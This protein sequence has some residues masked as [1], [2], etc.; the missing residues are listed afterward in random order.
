MCLLLSINSYARD[1]YV[2]NTS[3]L[4]NACTNAAP[5]DVIYIAAGTYQGPFVLN[6]KENITLRSYNGPV[7]LEGS[8]TAT[9]NGIIILSIQNSSNITVRDL[10]LRNNWGNFADGIQIRGSGDGVSIANCEFFNIGW[11][12]DKQLLPNAGQNAH[13]IIAVG[14]EATS[15]SNLFI[16]GNRIHDC[17]TGYSES[18]TLAGNVEFFLVEGNRLTNNTNIG[19]D[20]AGHFPWT[21]APA[22]VNFARSGIIRNNVVSDY[23]G[24]AALDAAGGIYVDGGSFVTVEN[25]TVY[26]YKVGYSI[27]CEVPGNRNSGNILR[28]NVAYNCS[29]SGAFIG[30]NTS[31]TVSNTLVQNNTFYKCGF[32]TF[33]NGQLA[34][35][36]NENTRVINNIMYPTGGRTAMVQMGGT[37]SSSLTL[38][39]NLYWRDSG[40]TDNLFFGISGDAAAVLADPLFVGAGAGDFH[41][42]ND[43]PAIDRGSMSI[44][45]TGQVDL[46]ATA[47]VVNGTVDIG[48]DEFAGA[49]PVT[50]AATF[51]Q[52]CSFEGTAVSL[53][54][55]SYTLDE[56]RAR[57]ARND[58]FSSLQV[59][60]GYEVTLY[61]HDGFWGDIRTYSADVDCLVRDEFNDECS[62]LEIRAISRVKQAPSKKLTSPGV[63]QTLVYPNPFDRQLTFG[64]DGERVELT[65][66][67][68]D[69]Q[70]RELVRRTIRA[71]EA[72]DLSAL[73]SG[74]YTVR[75]LKPGAAQEVVRVVKR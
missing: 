71:G 43:S 41:L 59:Q 70:G 26:N 74:I 30:S 64:T 2:D 68:A 46:D 72:L 55:G 21:G 48:T 18:L 34:L 20:A 13:A 25:N 61:Q 6:G 35:Q 31:S 40:N 45:F 28:N 53:E 62:S 15:I 19:I 11:S 56:L 66:R 5:G 8:P 4:A 67:V 69:M 38:T 12:P 23:A 3:S 42:L 16:G 54:V 50:E 60:P 17:V 44:D 37:T 49:P 14:S 9:T 7:H 32:G 29:L 47:R 57:G 73:A 75:I 10:I 52:H 27:G 39:N 63:D 58:D 22:E 51:Y 65:L 24:P 1:V 33:D 36:N